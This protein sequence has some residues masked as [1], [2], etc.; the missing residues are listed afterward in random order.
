MSD[1]DWLEVRVPLDMLRDDAGTVLVF[2]LDF[3]VT[4]VPEAPGVTLEITPA[5]APAESMTVVPTFR[6]SAVAAVFAAVPVMAD[7]DPIED[8]P[9]DEDPM[10]EDPMEEPVLDDEPAG[11]VD[12][13]AGAVG[14]VE[15]E[16][17]VGA[18]LG[19]EAGGAIWAK[20]GAAIRPA[21]QAARIVDFMSG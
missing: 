9:M 20:A 13:S 15:C 8:E 2:P 16:P 7:P 17:M 21:A 11:S 4:I 1:C 14:G 19:V 18:V 3:R 10:D 5:L 6:S 12:G